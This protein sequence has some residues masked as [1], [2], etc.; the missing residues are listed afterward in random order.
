[1]AKI[2]FEDEGFINPNDKRFR[3]NMI[4]QE[5]NYSLFGQQ[6]E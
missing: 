6:Q 2:L 1:M 3:W 4:E 5:F